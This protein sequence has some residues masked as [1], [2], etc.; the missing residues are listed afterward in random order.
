MVT[1]EEQTTRLEPKIIF[2][3]IVNMLSLFYLQFGKLCAI[4]QITIKQ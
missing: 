1:P 3:R 2:R 4:L